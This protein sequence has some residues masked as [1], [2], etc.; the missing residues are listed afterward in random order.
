[1]MQIASS[2][3]DGK[4]ATQQLKYASIML[5]FSHVRGRRRSMS[6]SSTSSSGIWKPGDWRTSDHHF[7]LKSFNSRFDK[8]IPFRPFVA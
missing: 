3:S 8:Y 7:K 6:G 5:S 1:M 4:L 2:L